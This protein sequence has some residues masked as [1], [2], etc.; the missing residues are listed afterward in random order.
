LTTYKYNYPK[1]NCGHHASDGEEGE[2]DDLHHHHHSEE[3]DVSPSLAK[4]GSKKMS[5]KRALSAVWVNRSERKNVNEDVF[6]KSQFVSLIFE[7]GE[8]FTYEIRQLKDFG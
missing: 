7:E 3:E 1:A 5:D 2:E 6:I 4:Q 8:S